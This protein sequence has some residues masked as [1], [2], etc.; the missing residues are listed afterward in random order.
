MSR[1]VSRATRR[2]MVARSRARRW[3]QSL[4]EKSHTKDKRRKILV[5]GRLRGGMHAVIRQF[6]RTTRERFDFQPVK[7][8]ERN[9]SFADGV[10]FFDGFGDVSLC[11]RGRFKQAATCRK[12]S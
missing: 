9:S 5:S 8:I 11:E 7:M 2:L 12:L 10:T 1:R 3:Q 6:V 4:Q